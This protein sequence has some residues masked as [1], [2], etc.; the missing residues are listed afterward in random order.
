MHS[1]LVPWAALLPLSDGGTPVVAPP[2][3]AGQKELVRMTRT[4]FLF[5]KIPDKKHLVFPDRDRGRS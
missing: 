3:R 4:F 2:H 1:C 5:A